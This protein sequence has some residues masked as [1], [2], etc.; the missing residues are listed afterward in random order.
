M[1]AVV[2]PEKDSS[3]LVINTI[4]LNEKCREIPLYSP[5]YMFTVTYLDETEQP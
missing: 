3:F 5:R 2:K 1:D 4:T